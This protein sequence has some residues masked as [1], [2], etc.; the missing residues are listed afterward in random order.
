MTSAVSKSHTS[1]SVVESA[2]ENI[3]DLDGNNNDDTRGDKCEDS[4]VNLSPRVDDRCA[5]I[6]ISP[7]CSSCGLDSLLADDSYAQLARDLAEE[8]IRE[9]LE[10]A[11][12][13][14]YRSTTLYQTMYDIDKWLPKGYLYFI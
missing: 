7:D 9:A 11:S 4:D 3:D 12:D 2:S 8:A 6:P 10:E 14:A 5:S 13:E 1:L